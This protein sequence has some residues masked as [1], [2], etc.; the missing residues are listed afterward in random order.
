MLKII[1]QQAIQSLW[2]QYQQQL[3]QMLRITKYLAQRNITQLPLDHFAVIDLP[4]P[5]T[6]IPILSELFISLGFECRGRGYL[7]D[8]QNDFTWLAEEDALQAQPLNVLPQAV[9]A[10]FRL[11]EM[12][13]DIRQI[14]HHYSSKSPSETRY[15]LKRLLARA[16]NGDSLAEKSFQHLFLHYFSGRDWPLPTVYDYQTVYEFNPLLAW[17][18]VFGRKPNHF[19]LSIHLMEAFANLN[20]FLN[21]I[22]IEVQLTLN[23]DGGLIKGS[24]SEGIAQGGTHGTPQTVTL[25]DGSI[26]MPGDFVEFV[27]RYANVAKPTEWQDYFTGFIAHNANYVIEALA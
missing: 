19:T 15:E 24:A 6:G 23:Y 9:I 11:D 2:N 8:K 1:R 25:A 18:L 17:V 5:H 4:G 22:E 12:P 16:L 20:A 7:P 27:W 14:I 26:T 10:D 21:F 13:A 3:P